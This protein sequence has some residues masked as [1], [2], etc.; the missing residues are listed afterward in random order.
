LVSSL[1]DTLKSEQYNINE[2]SWESIKDKI[3]I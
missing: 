3:V 2:E 1:S